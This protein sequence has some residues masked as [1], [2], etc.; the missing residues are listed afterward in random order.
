MRLGHRDLRV[1][2]HAEVVAQ[3]P[4]AVLALPVAV[5]VVGAQPGAGPGQVE[6]GDAR[7]RLAEVPGPPVAQQASRGGPVQG[8]V[9]RRCH[10]R[11]Q[12][13]GVTGGPH[14]ADPVVDAEVERRGSIGPQARPPRRRAAAWDEHMATAPGSPLACAVAAMVLPDE[15]SCAQP[16][17][18][19]L[20]HVSSKAPNALRGWRRSTRRSAWDP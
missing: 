14:H 20:F 11:Q 8:D 13:V 5:V 10:G 18:C 16:P 2:P 9:G 6:L 1:V 4:R 3:G 15:P 12:G 17:V 7:R 19:L